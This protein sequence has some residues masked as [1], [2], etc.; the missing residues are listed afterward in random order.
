MMDPN[1]P[2]LEDF[3]LADGSFEKY[4]DGGVP[5]VYV[6]AD[7]ADLCADCATLFTRNPDEWN[8]DQC[9]VVDWYMHHEGPPVNC[10]HC[11]TD[12][13]SQYGDPYAEPSEPGEGDITTEDHRNFYQYGKLAFTVEDG[14][15]IDVACREFMMGREFFPNVWAISDHGN[16]H[17][18]KVWPE[19]G[20]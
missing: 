3:K 11:Y 15:D 10:E 13:E 4:T 2:T 8:A 12:I 19:G 17:L 6:A 5:M 9:T 16:A 18:M 7:L 14:E 1:R 20:K